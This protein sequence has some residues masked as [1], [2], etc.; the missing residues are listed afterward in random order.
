MLLGDLHALDPFANSPTGNCYQFAL[1]Q[2][3]AIGFREPKGRFPRPC[4]AMPTQEDLGTISLLCGI[5]A[6]R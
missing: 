4:G 2:D 5:A 3:K 1:M 6:D